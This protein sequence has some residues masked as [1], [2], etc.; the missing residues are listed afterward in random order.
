MNM[1]SIPLES[2]NSVR[3]AIDI[4]T[5]RK[6]MNQDAQTVG[7][8][9]NNMQEVNSKVLEHSVTPHKGSSID[10]SV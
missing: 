4:A 8:L 1:S 3:Q 10:V 6:S 7:T 9:I 2:L 5:L